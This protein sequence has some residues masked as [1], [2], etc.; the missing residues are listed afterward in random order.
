MFLQARKDAGFYT[1][2]PHAG[3]TIGSPRIKA[4]GTTTY[5]YASPSPLPQ[6]ACTPHKSLS[7]SVHSQITSSGLCVCVCVSYPGFVMVFVWGVCV[8]EVW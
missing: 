5:L 3:C 6:G 4:T 8:C 7:A 1:C 2:D